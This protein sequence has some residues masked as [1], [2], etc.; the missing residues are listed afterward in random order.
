[1][2]RFRNI[3]TAFLMWNDQ[4]LLLERSKDKEIAPG[5]WFGVGGHM[6]PGELNDP[7][8][9]VYREIYEETGLDKKKMESL[10]LK[11]IIYNRSDDEEVV[12]NHIFFGDVTAPYVVPNHEGVLHWVSR[13]VALEKVSH[14][15]VNKVLCHYFKDRR[16]DMLLGVVDWEE[17]YVW[18]YPI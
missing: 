13:D 18:W 6:E 8:G 3:V 15:V 7:Y 1:M 16:E 10:D 2:L 12:V 9:S 17:P 5:A 4:V 11:Y 14:P